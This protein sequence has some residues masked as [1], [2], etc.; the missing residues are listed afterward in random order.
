MEVKIEGGILKVKHKLKRNEIYKVQVG[1]FSSL[2]IY[3]TPQVLKGISSYCE[4][5]KHVLFIDYDNVPKW[6][7]EQDYK[8][9]QEEYSLP[10]ALVFTTK[11]ESDEGVLFGNYHVLSVRKFYPKQIYEILSK[12]HADVNFMSMPLRSKFRNWTIRISTKRRKGRPKFVGII[13][14]PENNGN[15]EVSKPHIEMLKKLYPKIKIPE[16]PKKDNLTKCFLQE[17]E[18]S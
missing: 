9:L 6:L 15:Y 4:D 8:R 17:Y 11:E 18:A 5:G 14:N 2:R 7:I 3:K 12:T 13:G 16:Y 1:K 10:Q